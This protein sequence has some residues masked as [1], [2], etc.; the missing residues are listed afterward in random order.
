MPS[1]E[2][3]FTDLNFCNV[4]DYAETVFGGKAFE[5]EFAAMDGMKVAHVKTRRESDGYVATP[6]IWFEPGLQRLYG[7]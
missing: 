2:P 7:E 1:S 4:V 6:T 5:V 3:R